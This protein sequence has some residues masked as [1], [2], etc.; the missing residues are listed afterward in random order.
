MLKITKLWADFAHHETHYYTWRLIFTF[1]L[2][3]YM[4][5]INWMRLDR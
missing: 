1:F 4:M 5:G 3:T 2:D